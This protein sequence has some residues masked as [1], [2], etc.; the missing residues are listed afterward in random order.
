MVA[1]APGDPSVLR[2]EERPDPRPGDRQVV[3]EVSHAGVN[4]ADVVMRRGQA[5]VQP[6][7][8]LGVEGAGVVRDIGA[9]VHELRPGD[10]VAWTPTLV[11]SSIGSYAEL[12]VVGADQA[13]PV[14]D[15]IGLELAAATILQ[16]VTAHYLV[17]DIRPVG[18]G[19][20]VLVHAAAGGTGRTVVQWLHHVGAE[21]LATVGSDAKAAVAAEAGAHHVIRYREVDLVDAVRE[22]T[23]GAGVDYVVDGVGGPGFR[24]NL[25]VL[26]DGGTV[27]V[28][29][30]AGGRPEPFSPIEL[31]ARGLTVR[32]AMSSQFLRSRAELLV[33]V[34]EVWTGVREGWLRPL[35]HGVLPLAE[36]ATAHRVL[37]GRETVGKLV[38]AVGSG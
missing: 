34:D 21:V 2:M 12:V 16:G 29:G 33:K 19:T 35:V 22:V 30:Q 6:P 10:P 15:D 1:T 28:F 20:R 26:A 9:G 37:E 8:V 14:P 25:K 4:F 13:V 36:A 7:L 11:A 31:T 17:H 23:G 3:V 32:G 18:P 24:A 27:C 5:G 38:L